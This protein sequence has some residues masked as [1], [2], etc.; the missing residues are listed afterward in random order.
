MR[1]VLKLKRFVS[2][3][4][5]CALT[6]SVIPFTVSVNAADMCTVNINETHQTIHGFGGINLPEWV[7]QGDMT[8]A[9]VQKAFG[10]GD[11]ELGL[12]VLRV[13]VSDDKNMWQKAVPTAQKA[14]SLGATVFATPWNPPESMRTKGN[15]DINSGKYQLIKDKWPDYA[16]HLNSFI[17]YMKNNGVNLYSVSVQNEPDYASEWTYWSADDLASFIAQ[18]GKRVTNGTSTKLMSPESFQYKK[19]LYEPILNNEQA[20][21]NVDVW[22][23][24]FYGTQRSQMDYPALENSGK[25]IWMTEVYVPNSTSDSA[26]VWP[27]ALEVSANIHNGLVVGN[28]SAYVWWYIRRSYGLLK[29]DGNISKRGYCMAQYSKFV[30]PGDVRVDVTEQP[31]SNVFVSAFKNT[32]KSKVTIVAVNKSNNGYAQQFSLGN[33][34]IVNVDRW[35]TSSTENLAKTSNL[36]N[37][38]SSFWA[39]LP[40]QSVSTFVVSLQT[41]GRE[42]FHDTFEDTSDLNNWAPHGSTVELIQ[43][44]RFPYKGINA[45][46]VSKRDGKWMGAERTLP[47]SIVPGKTYSLS[48]NVCTLDGADTETYYLKLY[49]KDASNNDRYSTVAEGTAPKNAYVQLYN[50]NYTVPKDAKN[51]VLFIETKYN[52]DNYYIDEVIGASAGTEIEGAGRPDIEID[53]VDLSIDKPKAGSVPDM[54][55]DINTLGIE[56][57]KTDPVTWFKDGAIMSESDIFEPGHRY[58]ITV[59]LQAKEGYYYATD[60]SNNTAV[61][62]T[63]NN[64]SATIYKALEQDPKEVIELYYDFGTL[65]K[66]KLTSVD[67][68]VNVPHTG[69]TPDFAPRITEGCI[70]KTPSNQTS[71]NYYWYGGVRWFDE[72]KAMY[73]KPADKFIKGHEYTLIVNFVPDDYTTFN[74]KNAQIN[75]HDVTVYGSNEIRLEYTFKT[76]LIGDV[77]KNGSVENADAALLMKY[78]T[79]FE[80]VLSELQLEAAKV[81]DST[82][83]KPDLLDVIAILK[84]TGQY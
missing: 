82:K 49:Y 61:T 70:F 7:S 34:K 35:R 9:Q 33:N 15:G 84:L 31:E 67:V 83:E 4:L 69:N 46:L 3:L 47:S 20:L 43:S 28:M 74:V 62:G 23:T 39:Q 24:H 57:Y 58:S 37:D 13:Y 55:A 78:V 14:S 44:G 77:D 51:M 71:S 42:Y 12:T 38:G 32:D 79:G 75:G 29:E 21:A 48:A 2:A 56:L 80:P 11:D 5:S 66:E 19:S 73:M 53:S 27:D 1:S 60:K 10:N 52:T 16:D 25:P 18:Y 59:W 17:K 26:D 64:T 54:S 63:L 40:A 50:K 45:M 22:G 8:S 6:L 76:G 41:V 68:T 72:S 65:E 81:T 30:R 36:Q